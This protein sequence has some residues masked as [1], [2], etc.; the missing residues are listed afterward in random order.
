[1]GGRPSRTRPAS[2]RQSDD[3]RALP[4]A[5][6]EGQN[7]GRRRGEAKRRDKLMSE[8]L[9]ELDLWL[10]DQL[11]Q[12]LANG[13]DRR[14]RQ[15]TDFAGRMVDAQVPGVAGRLRRI[16]GEIGSLS[17][18][19][20]IER[21]VEEF[22]GL[23]LLIRAWQRRDSLPEDLAATVRSHLGLTV[24]AD[25]VLA[26][27]GV[28][29]TWAVVASRVVVEGRLTSQRTWLHGRSSGRW[30]LLLAF[31]TGSA[32][33]S[34]PAHPG[35]EVE[36]TVHFYPGRGQLRVAL[37]D[38]DLRAAPL[39]DW[40]PPVLTARRAREAWRDAVA[41]DPWIE[42]FPAVVRGRLSRTD[43]RGCALADETGM[44]PLADAPGPDDGPPDIGGGDLL[45]MSAD[46]DEPTV[47]GEMT[48]RGLVPLGL[49]EAGGVRR[50]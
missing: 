39:T 6:A 14:P 32:R 31:A 19:E 15:L 2:R 13:V 12:G 20:S 34:S 49:V 41:R 23:H 45:M 27:P 3:R 10:A 11:R 26:T 21:T 40:D 1:M 17:G 18:A 16:A 46:T 9:E 28:A 48:A 43:A 8:G 50:L 24:R 37:P 25:D 4:H 29:D 22:G 42:A 38:G 5:G 36:A 30:A 7:G 33:A 47:A 44:I 35:T